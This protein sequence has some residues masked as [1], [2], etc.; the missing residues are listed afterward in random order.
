MCD[1]I[2]NYKRLINMF[3]GRFILFWS[4]VVISSTCYSQV[5]SMNGTVSKK[6]SEH[7]F[8]YTNPITR[9]TAISMR[10]H[11]IIKVGKQ[12]YCTGTSEPVWTGHNPGVRLLVSDDLIHW[13]QH[14]WII[15]AG[16]LSI[17]CPYNGRF[18]A[19]EIHFI[20]NRYWLTVNS[21]KVTP[22][23]PKGMK[24]H[25]IWLFVADKV[26]G[27]YKLVNGPLTNQY[28]NDATLFEDEDGQTYLYC[29]GNGL[30]QAKID[31]NTGILTTPVQKFLDKTAPGYPDWITG[32]IEG[33]FV[34]KRDG[35]YFMFFSTWTRGYEVGL[36]KSKS[37]LGPWKLASR[38]PIFGTKK[39]GYRPE[40]A[41]TNLKFQDSQDP[42]CETGH[43]SI[44][45]GPDGKLWSSCHYF[46]YEKRP[47]PYSQTFE[48]WELKP[49][50]GIEPVTYKDGMFYINPPTWTEQ[51]IEY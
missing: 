17:D 50:M 24:T 40:L 28:N 2:L 22:E 47:Y 18:W 4:L 20:K 16:K 45:E 29:S 5:N 48:P 23:D 21:G 14:S 32:G 8:R 51:L 26:T 19:P 15:D 6:L 38:E 3:N 1:F 42:Y 11:N 27:P 35:T 30:F 44:F 13:K 37:P 9:D 41:S 34:L 33:P 39:R 12:W 36:L 7:E 25:S 43:N 49:Q 46:M 31:L 10:D